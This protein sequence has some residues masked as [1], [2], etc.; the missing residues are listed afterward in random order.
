MDM[1][2]RRVGLPLA[3]FVS[4]AASAT[5]QVFPGTGAGAIPDGLAGTPPMYNGSRTLSFAVAGLSTNVA[6]VAVDIT[7]THAWVGDIDMVLYAPGGA[8]SLTL[9]SRITV[10]TAGGFGD[11]SNYA[12]TYSFSDGATG[13]NI[14]SVALGPPTCDNTCNVRPGVYRTTAPGGAGQSNPAPVTSLA[15]TFGGLTPAAANGTWTLVVRDA[16]SG[17]LGSVTA[18]NLFIN[19]PLDLIFTD[20]FEINGTSGWSSTSADGGDLSA[21]APAA[22]GG[23]TVGVQA[24]VNDVNGLYCQDDSPT[25]EDV[26]RARFYF[27]PNGFD[28]GEA[29]AHLRTRILLVFEDAP[30]RRLGAVVLRRQGG[31]YAI[32]ARAREDDNSQV[33]SP[34]IPI[35]DAPH[36]I[37]VNW[38]RA[39][40]P[41]ALDGYMEMW[42]DGLYQTG[43]YAL[44]NRASAV[45]FVRLGALSVKTGA[46]GTLYFDEFYSRRRS[47]IGP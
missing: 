34:F 36:V 8:P 6:S 28:P 46:T 42:L 4:L 21:A 37:E 20:G 17:D 41:D 10:T 29:Q 9:V 22:L 39:S 11:S 32:R 38:R 2:I 19:L 27:D 24:V 33:D 26:Y 23:T 5:A 3:L 31:Q 43:V 12:G 1:R 18:A 7:L 30:I 15:A 16:A 45:D 13:A 47:Y 44:D 35:T 25:N 14:W 40:G